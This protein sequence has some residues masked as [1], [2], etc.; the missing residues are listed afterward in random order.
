M[1]T[2]VLKKL[3]NFCTAEVFKSFKLDTRIYTY[4]VWRPFICSGFPVLG[5]HFQLVTK[6]S[7]RF[8]I[9]DEERYLTD[10]GE[11]GLREALLLFQLCFVYV[12]HGL[13]SS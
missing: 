3:C 10:T 11:S 2:I 9:R 8:L 6:E 12:F 7:Q 5:L 13:P 4:I 1:L